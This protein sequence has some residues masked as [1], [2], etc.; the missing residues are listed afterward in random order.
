MI[1][2]SCRIPTAIWTDPQVRQLDIGHQWMLFLLATQ[3]DLS[4]AGVLP[5]VISRWV[6]DAADATTE[7]VRMGLIGLI[8]Y[9]LITVD[10]LT[11]EVWVR[12]W[13]RWQRQYPNPKNAAAILASV[14]E[15][16]SP[17]IRRELTV[18]LSTLGLVERRSDQRSNGDQI[19]ATANP[20]AQVHA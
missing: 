9:D 16:A 17:T 3:P 20:A 2:T 12:P 11:A 7:S 8:A 15:V 5:L 13:V 10:E 1:R 6:G 4:P 19:T 14:S 18:D